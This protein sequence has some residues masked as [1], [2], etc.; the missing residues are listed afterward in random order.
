[1]TNATKTTTSEKA[2]A[3]AAR[4]TAKTAASRR[5]P[6][7]ASTRSGDPR[8]VFA[9]AVAQAGW[10]IDA[11]SPEQLDRPTP[12]HELD[13]RGLLGHVADVMAR[14]RLIG[15]GG[16]PMA[17]GQVDVAGVADD[18]WF[19]LFRC[20]AYEV[21]M[22]WTDAA[23]LDRV[24]VLPWATTTG[25]GAMASYTGELTVHTWD[26]AR[27]T[28][29]QPTWDDEVVDVGFGAVR[30][31]LPARDRTAMFETIAAQMPAGSRPTSPPFGEAVAVPSGAPAI[32]RL[33]AW[34][35][36]QP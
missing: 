10:V 28:G 24:V 8:T 30:R 11:I 26:L 3:Q 16:N 20:R 17:N 36:R 5:A 12:C 33:V 19:D 23:A 34:T 29:Q 32:D 15:E 7:A 13:V 6:K 31:T 9:K 2:A 35:G 1:M 4:P 18:G 21:Q 27:A 14:V 25:A 22:A